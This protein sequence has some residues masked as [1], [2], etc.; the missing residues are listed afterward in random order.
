MQESLAHFCAWAGWSC[1]HAVM[2]SVLLLGFSVARR[3]L[4]ADSDGVASCH[5]GFALVSAYRAVWTEDTG[6]LAMS[7]GPFKLS[8]WLSL[9]PQSRRLSGPTEDCDFTAW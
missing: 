9:Q 8:A 1:D 4:V 2:Y 6:R 5:A 3:H 7:L